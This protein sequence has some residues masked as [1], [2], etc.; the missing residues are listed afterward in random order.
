MTGP[1][2]LLPGLPSAVPAMPVTEG[3]LVGVPEQV[4][5]EVTISSGV[6]SVV[7]STSSTRRR[8]TAPWRLQARPG[9]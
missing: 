9:Q 3:V 2:L 6:V 8:T 7:V 5:Y 4:F 1:V